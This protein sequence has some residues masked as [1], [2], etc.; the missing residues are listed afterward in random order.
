MWKFVSLMRKDPLIIVCINSTWFDHLL[1]NIVIFKCGV[2]VHFFFGP[3]YKYTTHDL[4][5]TGI[6]PKLSNSINYFNNSHQPSQN[7]ETHCDMIYW[8]GDTMEKE[9]LSSTI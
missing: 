3:I 1:Y 8:S 9:D 4:K 6:L 2:S 7:T 5:Q